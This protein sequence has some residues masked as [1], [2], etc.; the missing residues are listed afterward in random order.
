[1][2]MASVWPIAAPISCPISSSKYGKCHWS[3]AST[4]PSSDTN[5]DAT[6]LLMSTS[7]VRSCKRSHVHVSAT[8]GAAVTG[9]ARRLRP[10]PARDR[11]GAPLPIDPPAAQNHHRRALISHLRL[12]PH[13]GEGYRRGDLVDRPCVRV[14]SSVRLLCLD[15]FEVR[16]ESVETVFP[17]P[18]LLR[19]P[20]DE[21]VR[22][23]RLNPTGP[24]LGV[25]PLADEPCPLETACRLIVNGSASSFTLA[26]PS[27][28]RV[29][30]ARRVGSAKAEKA[31]SSR[32]SVSVTS[33]E[34][35]QRNRK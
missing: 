33:Y 32:S 11:T 25:H 14:R 13:H 9:R 30:I 21:L 3:G 35:R 22:R 18:F 8:V 6:T 17:A 23:V 7:F 5:S 4:T 26:S 12:V 15:L 16:F 28:R 27:E 1:M 34:G 31:A 2:S 20:V 24:A 19:N 10:R 29:K